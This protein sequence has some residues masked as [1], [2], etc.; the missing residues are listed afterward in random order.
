VFDT[1]AKNENQLNKLI[2]LLSLA[3]GQQQHLQNEK[4]K[5]NLNG[6]LAVPFRCYR[7]LWPLCV[8]K[9]KPMP[10]GV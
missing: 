5:S 3:P 2:I 8:C 9:E 4:K 6:L 7:Q 10:M 1:K